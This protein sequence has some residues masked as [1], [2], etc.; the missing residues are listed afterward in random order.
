MKLQTTLNHGLPPPDTNTSIRFMTAG[1]SWIRYGICR[2]SRSLQH[3]VTRVSYGIELKNVWAYASTR[4]IATTVSSPHATCGKLLFKTWGA[5]QALC[6]G[7]A[8]AA[9]WDAMMVFERSAG[10]GR[11]ARPGGRRATRGCELGSAPVAAS[12]QTRQRT[13]LD[14]VGRAPQVCLWPILNFS[15]VR[16]HY[17]SLSKLLRFTDD[18]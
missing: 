15:C 5:P 6:S 18:L 17:V 7:A 13:N 8:A 4:P 12:E 16:M 1:Q 14:R 2:T 9:S 11:R 10:A 3:S